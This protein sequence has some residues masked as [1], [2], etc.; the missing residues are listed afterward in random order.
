MQ[1][2]YSGD[3]MP[4]ATYIVLSIH[5]ILSRQPTIYNI[6]VFDLHSRQCIEQASV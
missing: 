6:I 2:S 5:G 1:A 3:Y 4:A